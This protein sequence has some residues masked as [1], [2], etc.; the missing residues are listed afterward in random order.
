MLLISVT[1]PEKSAASADCHLI[2][3]PVL[4]LNVKF[5]L[6]VPVHTV[7]PPLILPPT[8]AAF[9][10]TIPLELLSNAHAPLVT[11]AR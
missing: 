4:P 11:T 3:L 5:V 8:L 7:A 10:V 2:T 9:T 1:V 6:F